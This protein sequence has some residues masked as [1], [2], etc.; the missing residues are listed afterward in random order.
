M[1]RLSLA[2]LIA[3]GA[4]ASVVACGGGGGGGKF[5]PG[6]TVN[7]VT[8]ATIPSGTTGQ[9][10]TF[11]IQATFPNPPGAYY[12]T[13]GSLPAGTQLDSFTGIVTGYPRE[14]GHY[15][16]EIAAQDGVEGKLPPGRDASYAEDRRTFALDVMRG[17]VQILPQL[18]PTAQYRASY[19]YQID[20]AGGS[21]PYTFAQT[22]RTLPAGL[23]VSGTGLVPNFPTRADFHSYQFDVTVTD[24]LGGQHM[25]TLDLDVVVLPLFIKTSALPEAA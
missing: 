3:S 9:P 21:P 5:T 23:T 25:R 7:I 15:T 10:I 19:A 16:F 22:G 2:T 1:K 20:V 17:P 11:Q 14:V 4:L 8:P 13:G 6:A 24:S 12:V 18:P